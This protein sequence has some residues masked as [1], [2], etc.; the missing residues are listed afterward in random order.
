MKH[1]KLYEEFLVEKKPAGAPDF[2]DSDAP[3]AGQPPQHH[4]R[5]GNWLHAVGERDQVDPLLEREGQVGQADRR[6]L[7]G[8]RS[9]HRGVLRRGVQ[10]RRL[11][12]GSDTVGR[13]DPLPRRV[14]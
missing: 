13:Q 9:V 2:H 10:P 5:Q 1:L 4:D 12:A 11:E 7:R 6:H 8:T 3:D 14:H